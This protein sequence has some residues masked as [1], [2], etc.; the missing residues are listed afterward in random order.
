[1]KKYS[2][3]FADAMT[4]VP[5]YPDRTARR[6]QSGLNFDVIFQVW[7]NRAAMLK[8]IEM[9]GRG[10]PRPDHWRAVVRS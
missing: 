10:E 4:H 3:S 5:E 8:T 7:P 2:L 6:N 9:Q 1:M